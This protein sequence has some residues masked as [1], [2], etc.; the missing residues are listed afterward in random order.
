M[1]SN[2]DTTQNPR[3]RLYLL[4]IS[5]FIKAGYLSQ[6][7]MIFLLNIGFE[8]YFLT[9]LEYMFFISYVFIKLH[10]GCIKSKCKKYR[11]NIK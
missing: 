10:Q 11:T 6:I 4:I 9:T 8:K 2:I 1:D 7:H 3:E 5:K